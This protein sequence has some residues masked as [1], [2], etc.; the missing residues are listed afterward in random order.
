MTSRYKKLLLLVLFFALIMRLYP[1]VSQLPH[2]Y[3]H[4]EKNYIETALRFGSGTFMPYSLSHGGFFYIILFCVFGIYYVFGFLIGLFNSP[5]AFY[6][7]YLKDPTVLFLIGRGVVI[8]SGVL[9]IIFVYKS[10]RLLCHEVVAA[11]A[12]FFTAFSL[13]SIQL[14]SVAHADIMSVMILL[15][16]FY[17]GLKGTLN[18]QNSRMRVASLLVGLATATKYY[19]IFGFSFIIAFEVYRHI[20]LKGMTKKEAWN[21]VKNVMLDA[22]IAFAAFVAGSP[23]VLMNPEMLYRDTIAMAK[24]QLGGHTYSFPL[25]FHLR[26]HLRNGFGLPLALL[27]IPGTLFGLIKRKKAYIFTSLFP[28]TYYLLLSQ[29]IG[30]CHHLLPILPFAAIII[31]QF[32]YDIASRLKKKFRLLTYLAISL[33]V[34]LPTL[35]DSLALMLIMPKQDTRTIAKE[36]IESNI[37]PDSSI[38]MEGCVNEDIILGPT[39]LQNEKSIQR[40]IV[41]IKLKGGNA[42]PY[43]FLL[44]NYAAL[45]NATRYDIYKYFNLKSY[46]QID[47]IDP[48][49]IITIGYNDIDMGELSYRRSKDYIETRNMI[50]K[51]MYQYYDKIKE[52]HPTANFS[53]NYPMCMMNQ[54]YTI[55]R[56]LKWREIKNFVNGPAIRIYKRKS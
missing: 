50:K 18:D 29:S 9:M 21:T 31:A 41:N 52:F 13:L 53:F 20:F 4:D 39:I 33:L 43:Y 54:D 8:I 19:C 48:D 2:V 44:D 16:S 10:A 12:S 30:F 25:L 1:I 26:Y 23:F 24:D 22:V 27:I 7:S 28:L 6:L 55:L 17:I 36:W 3:W 15:L 35:K 47:H 51:R 34:I 5:L 38:A 40:S 45:N 42:R 49:Y 46:D 11:V 56:S 14:S 32:L 37:P